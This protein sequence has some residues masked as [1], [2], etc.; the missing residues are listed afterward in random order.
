MAWRAFVADVEAAVAGEPGDGAFDLPAVTG[1]AFS[2]V[3]AAAGNARCD[4]LLA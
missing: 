2:G 1:D 3:D 4:A